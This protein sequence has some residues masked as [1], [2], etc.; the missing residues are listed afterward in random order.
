ML[1]LA[2]LCWTTVLGEALGLH[3]LMTHRSFVAPKGL[4]RLLVVTST[5]ACQRGRMEWVGL[6]Q[7]HHKFSDQPNDHHDAARGQWWAHSVWML[8]DIPALE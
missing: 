6:H 4:E 2:I 8:R 7:H 1:A 5:L 3:R